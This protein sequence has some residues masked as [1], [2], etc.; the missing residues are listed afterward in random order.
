MTWSWRVRRSRVDVP[1]T[2][3]SNTA[4]WFGWMSSVSTPSVD[5]LDLGA[6]QLRHGR[7]LPHGGRDAAV[8]VGQPVQQ[9]GVLGAD[10]QT[11]VDA[12]GRELWVE[13]DVVSFPAVVPLDEMQLPCT[14][15]D[16]A[17]EERFAP[18]RVDADD[19]R[20]EAA[21]AQGPAR[22]VRPLRRAGSWSRTRPPR[23]GCWACCRA[24]PCS[25]CRPHRADRVP[26]APA[27]AHG[28]HGR[29]APGQVRGETYWPGKFW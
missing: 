5:H 10:A 27:S 16:V 18:A 15:P 8:H 2:T 19:V 9:V 25:A 22:R 6:E 4:S 11:G 21:L 17:Q 14:G 12:A 29:L 24:G 7:A 3:H 1:G 23:G 28:L 13:G 20:R 26:W